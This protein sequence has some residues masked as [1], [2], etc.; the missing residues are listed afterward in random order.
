MLGKRNQ[1]N[2]QSIKNEKPNYPCLGAETSVLEAGFGEVSSLSVIPIKVMS[3]VGC[4]SAKQQF[5]S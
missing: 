3:K 4:L 5:N 2:N 1:T